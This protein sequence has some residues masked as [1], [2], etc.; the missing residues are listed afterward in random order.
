MIDRRHSIN[1]TI[2]RMGMFLSLYLFLASIVAAICYGESASDVLRSWARILTSPSPLVTDYFRHGSL[3]AALLNAAMCGGSC[4]LM[5]TVLRGGKYRPNIWAGYFLVVAHCFYGLN[6]INMWPPLL[7][8]AICCKIHGL[9]FRDNLD[10]AMFITSFAP[11]FSELLFRYPMPYDHLT[12]NVFGWYVNPLTLLAVL[13]LSIIVGLALPPMLPGA[14]KLHRGYNLYNGGLATGLLGLLI[15]AFLFK[16]LGVPAQGPVETENAAYAAVGESYMLFGTVFYILLS[17]CCIAYGWH[18]N[19]KTFRGYRALLH[20]SGYQANFLHDYGEGLVW[21]NL[22]VYCLM[23]LAYFDTVILFTDGAGF[24]G[25]TFGIILAAM[26]FSAGGQHPGNVWPILLGYALLSVSVTLGSLMIGR[27]IPWTLSTQ[28]YM[29]GLAFATGLCPF[30]GKYGWK[31]G[32]I[33]GMLSAVM[34]T[35]TSAMHGGFVLYN[36]GLTAGISALILLPMLD[37]YLTHTEKWGQ[38]DRNTL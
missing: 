15:Y 30:S 10:R 26:T 12:R 1:I 37:T 29:N 22:G 17:I 16:T 20:D 35:T 21:V 36:G 19:G 8:F 4:A 34:C 28:G 7:G 32:V 18:L 31:I 13:A 14:A 9:R 23:M 2:R 11:F 24:T 5:M 3:S 25:A 27:P 33:A 6:F 38:D